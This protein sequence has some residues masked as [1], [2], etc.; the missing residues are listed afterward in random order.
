MPFDVLNRKG[1]ETAAKALWEKMKSRIPTKVSQLENDMGFIGDVSADF[2][3][4][5]G[6]GNLRYCNGKF[7]Y[8]DKATGIWA[9]TAATPSNVIVVNIIPQHMRGI[10]GMY[11][12]QTGH[13][14]LKWLEPLDTVTD[15]QVVCV[16]EKVTIRRKLGSSP[17]DESDGEF[18][19]EVLRPDFGS[20]EKAWFTDSSFTP[21]MGDVYYYKAFPMSTTGF[22]NDMPQNETSGIVARDCTVYGFVIDQDESDPDSMITYIED[23]KGFTPTHMDYA[24]DVFDYGNWTVENGA[25]FMDVRPCML[26]YDGTVDYYL[27]PHDYTLKEDGSPSDNANT[28]YGGNCMVQFPKTYYKVVDN[29]DG[30]ANIYISDK[31]ADAEY[32]CYSFINPVGGEIDYCYMPAYNGSLINGVL[33]SISNQTPIQRKTRQQ[34][35]NAAL[36][37]NIDGNQIWNTEV[38]SD[39]QLVN[40][41]LLLIGKSTNTQTVFGNGHYTGGSSASSLIKTGTMDKMGLFHG[42]NGT[43]KGVKVFG[44]E[45]YWGNQHRALC[46]YINDRG[47]QKVKMTYGTEDGSTANG[48]NLDGSGYIAV[49]NATPSGTFGGYISTEIFTPYG[50]IPRQASGSATTKYCDCLFFNNGQND[51]VW[52]GGDSYLGLSAGAFTVALHA[53]ASFAD[54]GIGASLSCKPLAATQAA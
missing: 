48:Y 30:T 3:T 39:R 11:D 1:L 18:V 7:Q 40:L 44:M 24:N 53:E 5:A 32:K 50:L 29:G 38:L 54:W 15:G 12:R 35:I 43:G 37:N 13:Y 23:N 33:R 17:A 31:K 25:W 9:D 16:V 2:L 47:T 34:E 42:T 51:Y 14:K 10:S 52:V 27:N 19:A 21:N 26:K 41:L 6:F 28:A 36:A 45:H 46:G 49:E 20:H 8:L 22:Y 4:S